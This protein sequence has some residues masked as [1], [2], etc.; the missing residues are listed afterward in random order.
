MRDHRDACEGSTLSLLFCL[1]HVLL[2][3]PASPGCHEVP[4]AWR[5]CQRHLQS[6]LQ[7]P[8]LLW[9][10]V[11][12]LLLLSCVYVTSQPTH[13]WIKRNIFIPYPRSLQLGFMIPGGETWYILNF[14]GWLGLAFMCVQTGV[15]H[16]HS[17]PHFSCASAAPGTSGCSFLW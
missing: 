13:W 16:P 4:R 12:G 8:H 2:L 9:R 1:G 11:R 7:G 3:P 14:L 15:A 17:V 6:S 5:T 10:K